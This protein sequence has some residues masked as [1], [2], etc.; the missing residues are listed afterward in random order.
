MRLKKN[1]WRLFSSQEEF[2]KIPF[3]PECS[4]KVP[5][6]EILYTVR[7]EKSVTLEIGFE[8]DQ[9]PLGTLSTPVGTG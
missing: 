7:S 6:V 2:H 1:A 8:K 4:L 5:S 9:L 3:P